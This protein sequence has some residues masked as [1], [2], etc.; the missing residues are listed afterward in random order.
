MILS[1][2]SIKDFNQNEK[3]KENIFQIHIFGSYQ[4]QASQKAW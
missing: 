2:S 4:S 1:F 3:N